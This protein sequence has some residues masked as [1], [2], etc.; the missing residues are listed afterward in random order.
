MKPGKESYVEE[1]AT[2][3]TKRK[4]MKNMKKIFALLLAFLVSSVSTNTANSDVQ[5]RDEKPRREIAITFDDLPSTY[6]GVQR[7]VEV[8][9]KLLPSLTSNKVP[10]I[11][12]VNERKLYEN[13]ELSPQMVATL[14]MWLDAG[15]ELGN[16]TYSHIAIDQVPLE[17]YQE[18]VIRGEVVTRKLLAEKGMKLRYFRHTQLRTGPTEEYK[19]GLAKF[20]SERGYMVAPVTIDNNDYMFQ[21]VYAEAKARGDKA[22]MKRVGDAYVPYM[23]S[24]FE[25]FEKLS[26]E[27][28]GYEVK[29]TLLLHAN[30]LNAD[31]FDDLARMMKRRG[32]RFISLDE[33]LKDKAYRLP[34]AQH[35]KGLSWIHRWMLAKGLPVKMEPNEPEFI[36]QLFQARQR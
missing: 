32:Y 17:K 26:K 33:A 4:G 18:D 36:T 22:M 5:N 21:V 31:Y 9:R 28:L 14:K 8:T 23:E 3:S 16:H 15:F 29:Q 30:D 10:A 20:L 19:R 1:S 24:V 27:F 35:Q 13:G 2:Q 12:F 6:G 25:H 11:G 34:E 7:T